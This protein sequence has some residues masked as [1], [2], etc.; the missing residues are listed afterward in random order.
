VRSTNY[1]N[2]WAAALGG[3]YKVT[4]YFVSRAGVRYD[5]TPTTNGYRDTT[6]PDTDRW[7]LGFG[8]TFRLN[9][10]SA[11]DFALNHTL[12]GTGQV[13]VTR[14]FFDGT[15]LASS[16]R[17]VGTSAPSTNTVSVNWRYAF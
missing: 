10:H 14:S 3:E 17:V 11:I 16:V 4:E 5:R 2:T 7:W 1:R 8:G 9:D 12:Y 15:P 13:D 6:L